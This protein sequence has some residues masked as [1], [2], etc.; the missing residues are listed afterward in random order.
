MK[1][2]CKI[3]K[4]CLL[5][6][7]VGERQ[8]HTVT[9]KAERG[10]CKAEDKRVKCYH[11]KVGNRVYRRIMKNVE[12]KGIMEHKWCGPYRYSYLDINHALY[13]CVFTL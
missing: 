5:L 2:Q 12:R 11:L 8:H 3:L 10:V 9:K 6:F 13:V 1:A 7:F 4:V